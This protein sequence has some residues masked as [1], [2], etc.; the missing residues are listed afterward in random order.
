MRDKITGMLLG[1][2]VGDALGRPV[3]GWPWEEVHSTFGRITKYMLPDGW[4]TERKAGITTDDTQLTLA[5]AEGL[6][7]SGGKPDMAAQ[8]VAHID[9]FNESTQGWGG[10]TFDAVRRLTQGVPWKL[11]G[12]RGRRITG[13]GNGCTM[14]MAPS[15]LLLLQRMPGATGFIADL[16]SMTHQTSIAVSAA[17]AH[18]SGL[19]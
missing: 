9:A 4:P 12:A 2:G 6:L 19:A 16:C 11:A 10:S 18:A 7:R 1:V 15:S 5:V 13:L 8:V 17:L 3:E 14:K